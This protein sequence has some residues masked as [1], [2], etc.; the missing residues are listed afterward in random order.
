MNALFSNRTGRISKNTW[1]D[2]MKLVH[3]IGGINRQKI[4]F[5]QQRGHVKLSQVQK[6]H[7]I[8]YS[9]INSKYIKCLAIKK[10]EQGM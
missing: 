7:C 1:K 8:L 10:C 3:E 5:G 6:K 2:M 9:R 4:I